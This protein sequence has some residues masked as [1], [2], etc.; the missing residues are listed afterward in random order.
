[1][2]QIEDTFGRGLSP[3]DRWYKLYRIFGGRLPKRLLRADWSVS[4]DDLVPS[5][6]AQ[7]PPAWEDG[8][9]RDGDVVHRMVIEASGVSLSA[10]DSMQ[11]A[12]HLAKIRD[13]AASRDPRSGLRKVRNN[14]F[15]RRPTDRMS[16]PASRESTS[17]SSTSRSST[18]RSSTS[19]SST[20]RSSAYQSTTDR[21][22]GHCQLGSGEEEGELGEDDVEIKEEEDEEGLVSL[23]DQ[24]RRYLASIEEMADSLQ[25]EEP[26]PG[27]D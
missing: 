15:R 21:P 16:L 5:S 25:D 26:E 3:K 11:L 1:M 13:E 23:S 2:Q 6:S 12:N 7:P 22:D 14:K 20:S 4:Y 17:R 18:S 8:R 24:G 9:I 19:R 27:R 10:E